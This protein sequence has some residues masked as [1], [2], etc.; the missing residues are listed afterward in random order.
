MIQT[1]RSNGLNGI[2]QMRGLLKSSGLIHPVGIGVLAQIVCTSP[3]C[4]EG[5]LAARKAA[6]IRA[7]IVRMKV[8]GKRRIESPFAIR[9]SPLR[10]ETPA[11]RSRR[12]RAAA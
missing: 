1:L 10:K 5:G 2:P 9:E 8:A 12:A 11:D 7:E 6:P 3:V 4:A